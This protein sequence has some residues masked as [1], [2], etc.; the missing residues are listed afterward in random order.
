MITVTKTRLSN[1]RTNHRS[2]NLA[3][4]GKIPQIRIKLKRDP[5][6]KAEVP[7]K[8]QFCPLKIASIPFN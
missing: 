2:S 5:R 8:N 7:F 3:T 6:T 1:Y 4:R